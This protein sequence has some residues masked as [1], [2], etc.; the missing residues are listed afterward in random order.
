MTPINKLQVD[1]AQF[2]AAA[3][4]DLAEATKAGIHR[5]GRVLTQRLKAQLRRNFKSSGKLGSRG[6]FRAVRFY[7]LE[8]RN[9]LGPASYVR[10]GVPWI[11]AFEDAE[12]ITGKRGRLVLLLEQGEK[13]GL[14]RITKKMP[15]ERVWKRIE[16]KATL[17]RV[18]GGAVVV[19]YRSRPGRRVPVYLMVPQVKLR[20][21]LSFYATAAQVG[22]TIADFIAE[23][24][25]GS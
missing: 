9:G 24:L 23:R 17:V 2:F 8:E 10:M 20:K 15:W 22:E 12:T 1:V 19:L 18:R 11:Q 16:K 25:K 13:E 3:Q 21:R 5:A 7:P 14:P 4:L 6:F